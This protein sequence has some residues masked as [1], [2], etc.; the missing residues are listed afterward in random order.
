MKQLSI[1]FPTMV[2]W[3]KKTL[4]KKTSANKFPPF[5]DL[6]SEQIA[7]SSFSN[8]NCI[9]IILFS[10]RLWI[11][12]SWISLTYFFNLFELLSTKSAVHLFLH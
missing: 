5:P 8:I 2:A 7:I 9:W 1:P 4:E 10:R 3:E 12:T 11:Y 6:S